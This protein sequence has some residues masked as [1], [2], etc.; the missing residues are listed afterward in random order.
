MLTYF[1]SAVKF[2]VWVF[3]QGNRPDFGWEVM[4]CEFHSKHFEKSLCNPPG[5][6]VWYGF[7]AVRERLRFLGFTVKL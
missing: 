6:Q 5:I 2:F 7:R 3:P 4:I 1:G